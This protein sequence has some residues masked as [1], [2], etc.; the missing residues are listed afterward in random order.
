MNKFY[1]GGLL[2][3]LSTLGFSAMPI[4]ANLAY[5]G[6]INVLTLLF[7]RFFIAA[8][9]LFV[10]IFIKVDNFQMC[11][12]D[13]LNFFMLG[14]V[15]FSATSIFYFY[16]LMFISTSLAVL[17]MYMYP[18][19]VSLYSMFIHKEKMPLK[20]IISL[21]VSVIG[22]LLVVGTS[23][24]GIN[25]I[26]LLLGIGSAIAYSCY[27]I[28]SNNVIR[29]HN[30][31]IVSAFVTLFTSLSILTVAIFSKSLIFDFS[32]GVWLP[33]III[34]FC[35]TVFA[36]LLFLKGLSLLGS[37]NSSVLAMLEPVIALGLSAL[38]LGDTLT[39]LQLIG[40]FILVGGSI[41]VTVFKTKY[42][43][44]SEI[45]TNLT[46]ALSQHQIP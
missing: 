29:D 7:L 44:V 2:I 23:F 13:F 4:I 11:K 37:A 30:P 15:C 32:T 6:G 5:A 12:K 31:A 34:S 43:K 19:I 22:M 42:I 36:I 17:L 33:I 1:L 41:M 26:G 8:I 40:C 45:Q 46:P 14:A 21:V 28:L 27:I 3:L 38:V 25:L 10:Y 24:G 16:A 39:P 20:S 9:V 35:S 18:I